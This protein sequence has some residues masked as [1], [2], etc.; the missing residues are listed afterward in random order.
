MGLFAGGHCLPPAPLSQQPPGRPIQEGLT[1]HPSP[2]A[3]LGL[4]QRSGSWCWSFAFWSS[5]QNSLCCSLPA[6]LSAACCF[7]FVVFPNDSFSLKCLCF[8]F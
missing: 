1:A 8:Y 2:T 7:L 4:V 3:Q 6:L 5:R